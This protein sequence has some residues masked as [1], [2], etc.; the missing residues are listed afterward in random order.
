[1]TTEATPLDVIQFIATPI[2]KSLNAEQEVNSASYTRP[3][4]E[5]VAANGIILRVEEAIDKRAIL[6]ICSC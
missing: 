5:A 6:N 1:M 3:P 2:I 4:T